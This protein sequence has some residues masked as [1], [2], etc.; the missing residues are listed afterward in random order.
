ML[1]SE[2]SVLRSLNDQ[3]QSTML[4]ELHAAK[5]YAATLAALEEQGQRYVGLCVVWQSHHH[6]PGTPRSAA[7]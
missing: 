7:R 4:T 1:E 5:D 3:L 6:R 2:N